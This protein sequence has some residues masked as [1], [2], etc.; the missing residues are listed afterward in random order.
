MLTRRIEDFASAHPHTRCLSLAWSIWS[1]VGMG[2]RLGRV[3]TLSARNISAIT[4][5]Q[6]VAWLAKLLRRSDA[7]VRTVVSG[8]FGHPPTLTHVEQ[9]L[10]ALRF[11]ER[12]REHVPRVELVADAELSLES[13][14]YLAD[15][16][17]RG[18][19][20]VPGV[21]GL[22]AFA[23]IAGALANHARLPTFEDV[24]F[25]QPIVLPPEGKRTV[26]VA[27][28][29]SAEPDDDRI[30]LRLRTD[31]NA[32]QVQH[33]SAEV[34]FVDRVEMIPTALAPA[35]KHDAPVVLEDGATLYGDLF[36]HRG[37]FARVIR[38]RALH[39]D[40]CVAEIAGRDE[41]F[42]GAFQPGRLCL[43]DPGARDAAIHAIQACVPDR[44]LLPIGVRRIVAGRLEGHALLRL[45]AVERGR[46]GG[47]YEYD[48]EISTPEGEVLERWEG[49]ALQEVAGAARR[50]IWPAALL[51]PRL[52]EYAKALWPD[53]RVRA[54]F[55][56]DSA[57]ATSELALHAARGV[58]GRL[59]HRLDGRPEIDGA[60]AVSVSHSAGHTLAVSADVDLAC[61]VEVVSER[62]AETWRD[63][64]GLESH[65][66]A[67]QLAD[68]S[69]EPFDV[70]A[71]R[72]WGASEC[73]RKLGLP[74][75]TPI[76]LS[77]PLGNGALRL[78]VG[79]T[80]MLS[81]S[82]RLA[83]ADAARIFSLLVRSGDASV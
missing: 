59:R 28:L 76:T 40:G 81:F 38:Y 15:H 30:Q 44:D 61:D 48:L 54:A 37:R 17:Y 62:S 52:E 55:L 64:L 65:A 66:A 46:H 33:I 79:R 18:E 67:R 60:G 47:R 75:E 57:A 78:H 27:A 41:P 34:G 3:E 69:E 14:P 12:V 16:V 51:A 23:Q 32:Y 35:P 5:D 72:L 82:A 4:P 24:R 68:R 22:E 63:M 73:V 83:G 53:A 70:S 80:E 36:F 2:E 6:G 9:T 10:P 25:E 74:R 8:R 77:T 20:I 21:I 7:P 56:P 50:E 1:G 31:G 43:G 39:S 26:R 19:S 42:F 71:T 29:A 58:P 49:L 45:R 11:L 13:D